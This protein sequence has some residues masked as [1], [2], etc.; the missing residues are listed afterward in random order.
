[1][2]RTPARPGAKGGWHFRWKGAWHLRWKGA[3]HLFFAFAASRGAETVAAIEDVKI[4][5]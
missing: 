3:W 1:M 4:F 5:M 2:T